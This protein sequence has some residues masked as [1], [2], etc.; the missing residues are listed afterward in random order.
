MALAHV[1]CEIELPEVKSKKS[2]ATLSTVR[3]L[4]DEAV[5][6]IEKS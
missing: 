6:V 1:L 2:A 4:I 5:A 3:R